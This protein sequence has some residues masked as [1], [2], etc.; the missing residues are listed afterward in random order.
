M[1]GK[2]ITLCVT[3]LTPSFY[4]GLDKKDERKRDEV[5]RRN[6]KAQAP[7]SKK[8][9]TPHVPVDSPPRLQPLPLCL[10][11]DEGGN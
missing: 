9:R 3:R 7:Q 5:T 8:R 4:S 11:I 1:N 2:V 10:F 6:R